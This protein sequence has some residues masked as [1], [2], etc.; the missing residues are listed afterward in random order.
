MTLAT[1]T[2]NTE[3][4]VSEKAALNGHEIVIERGLTAFTE[5]GRAMLA[6]SEQRL[7]RQTH[8]TFADY[9][10]DR[11][12]MSDRHVRRLMLAADVVAKMTELVGPMGPIPTSE[13]QARELVGLEPEEA[14]LVMETVTLTAPMVTAT[15]IAEVRRE[16]VQQQP[17]KDPTP[18]RTPITKTFWTFQVDLGRLE[19]RAH[20][21]LQDDRLARNRDVLGR[22]YGEIKR[23]LVA[24]TALLDALGDE[25]LVDKYGGSDV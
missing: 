9:C 21:L 24:L 14:V 15:A 23:S 1:T 12:G 5:A 10:A 2:M 7:Y 19:R 22:H 20:R 17:A 16:V 18:N 6:I 8:E 11:W 13:R 4:T 25:D 3:L